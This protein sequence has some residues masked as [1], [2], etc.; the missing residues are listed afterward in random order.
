MGRKWS[1]LGGGLRIGASFF[2]RRGVLAPER[3]AKGSPKGVV[4][5]MADL[6]N[7]EVD[8]ARVHPDVAR[9]F[10]DTGSLELHIVSQWRFPFSIMWWLVRPILA[11]IGQFVLPRRE[12]RI[13]TRVLPLDTARD[14]RADA[15]VVIRE[16]ADTGEVMQAVAYAT[17]ANGDTRFMNAAFPLPGGHLTGV[18]RLH[19]VGEDDEGR[20]AVG[21]TSRPRNG[22]GAGVW[23]VIGGVAIPLPLE[24]RLDLWAPSMA[25]AP[26][27][28]DLDMLPGATIVGRHEQRCCGVRMVTHRYWFRPRTDA[29]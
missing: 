21:V 29:S 28:L 5:A 7:P 4:D 6:G 25:S 2:E 8:V 14:G 22:D 20:L 12:A 15:R 17:W 19:V 9:F 13:L 16:Y 10:D 26:Q 27:P 23:Y 24:E 3:A 18:L 1:R 11:L